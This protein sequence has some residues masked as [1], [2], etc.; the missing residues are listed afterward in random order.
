MTSFGVQRPKVFKFIPVFIGTI[1]SFLLFW[2]LKDLIWQ[3]SIFTYVLVERLK[4]RHRRRSQLLHLFSNS[5][6]YFNCRL[7]KT[8]FKEGKKNFHCHISMFYLFSMAL[9]SSGLVFCWHLEQFHSAFGS[10]GLVLVTSASALLHTL[11]MDTNLIGFGFN[12]GLFLNAWNMIKTI[13]WLKSEPRNRN[14]PVIKR[15]FKIL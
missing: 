9:I 15:G 3:I 8:F 4:F 7:H 1:K 14:Y 6:T 12:R 11:T 10:I 5:I 2:S 13:K